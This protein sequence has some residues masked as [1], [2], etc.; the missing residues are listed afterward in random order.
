MHEPKAQ[1]FQISGPFRSLNEERFRKKKTRGY[2][3]P[4]DC[5]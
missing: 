1:I 4:A 2:G 5:D 3:G